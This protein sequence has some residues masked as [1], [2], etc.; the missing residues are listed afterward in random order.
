MYYMATRMLGDCGYSHYE[1]S[2]YSL[3]DRFSR[4]NKKYWNAKEYVGL[5]TSAASYFQKRRYNNKPSTEEYINSCGIE[6]YSAIRLESKDEAF[7]YAMMNLRLSEGFSLE[8]Y[9]IRF[10]VDFMIGRKEQ[11]VEFLKFGLID[12]D[13]GRIKLTERGFYVS[14]TILSELL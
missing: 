3:P 7:E 8:E 6:F 13:D 14:N 11:I 1:I 12:I 10:G 2:N 4:H 9:N 5:G